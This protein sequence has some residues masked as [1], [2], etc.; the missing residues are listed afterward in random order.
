M[1][2]QRLGG[3]GLRPPVIPSASARDSGTW[4]A[5]LRLGCLP[6]VDETRVLVG[7]LTEAD[8]LRFALKVL[9][10]GS[11]NALE[12]WRA[13][14]RG[15]QLQIASV[16]PRLRTPFGH[17]PISASLRQIIVPGFGRIDCRVGRAVTSPSTTAVHA[18]DVPYGA[19][20]SARKPHSQTRPAA[21]SPIAC[22][23]SAVQQ[24]YGAS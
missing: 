11:M 5:T 7:M 13:R 23:H 20:T 1:R 8:F 12:P 16:R 4:F 19:T 24:R 2:G 18:S 21:A 15:A 10:H 22:R 14:G 3:A 6:V 9:A 17:Q